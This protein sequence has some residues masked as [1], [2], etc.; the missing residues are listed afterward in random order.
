MCQNNITHNI[1]CYKRYYCYYCIFL[2]VVPPFDHRKNCWM[3]N[4]SVVLI[5]CCCAFECKRYWGKPRPVIKDNYPNNKAHG[6]HLG[7]TEPRWA[8]CWPHEHCYLG[9]NTIFKMHDTMYWYN[10]KRK[11]TRR[12]TYY[13]HHHSYSHRLAMVCLFSML[14]MIDNVVIG[15]DGICNFTVLY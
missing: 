11:H 2:H 4:H 7:P 1:V 8:P 15:R 6:A 14:K 9:S 3:P 13:F 5:K 10:L 12:K